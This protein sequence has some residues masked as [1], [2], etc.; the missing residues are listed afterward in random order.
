MTK[1]RVQMGA[2]SFV[3]VHAS[4]CD[5]EVLFYLTLVPMLNLDKNSHNSGNELHPH[6]TKE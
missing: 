6:S 3:S 2:V 4:G 5:L 1:S